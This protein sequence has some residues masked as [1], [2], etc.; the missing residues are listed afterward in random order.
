MIEQ[1]C[2]LVSSCLPSF[3]IVKDGKTY[4]DRFYLF[5]KDREFGNIFLHHFRSSDMDIGTNGLGLLHSH[6]W[7]GLSFV[8][9]G[10]YIE[11]RKDHGSDIV[12]RKVVKP[13]TF[14]FLSHKDF[15]R[16]DLLDEKKGAWTIFITGPRSEKDWCFWD[17]VTGKKI[18]WQEVDGA[19][20]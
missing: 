14:N 4:L 8:L 5:L 9:T 10:G 7:Y 16:V 18:P 19:I 11:E 20:A 13:F 3:S 1:I 12:F 6:R 2:E 17:R 15:H